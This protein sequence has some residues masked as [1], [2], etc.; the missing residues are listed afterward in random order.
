MS[1][2]R[3]RELKK[4]LAEILAL[5]QQ[6]TDKV[7]HKVKIQ[8]KIHFVNELRSLGED[9]SSYEPAINNNSTLAPC[10]LEAAQEEEEDWQP[11]VKGKQ[12]KQVAKPAEPVLIHKSLSTITKTRPDGSCLFQALAHWLDLSAGEVRRRIVNW[13]ADNATV[14]VGDLEISVWIEAEQGVRFSTYLARL[15][16]PETWGGQPEIFAASQ[17]FRINVFVWTEDEIP[18]RWALQHEFRNPNAKA[19]A[20]ILYVGSDHYDILNL[21]DHVARKID[22]K[23]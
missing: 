16:R 5:E 11:V 4:R 9:V 18:E 6:N 14:N 22:Q 19:S 3:V 2:K 10:L 1:P 21:K 12:R 8:R 20:H 17:V 13:L 7:E 15:K 23:Q